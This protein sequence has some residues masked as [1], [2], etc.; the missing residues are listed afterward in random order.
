MLLCHN[1]M[2]E[3]CGCLVWCLLDEVIFV[4]F[5]KAVVIDDLL[6]R[7]LWL[8]AVVFVTVR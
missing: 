2:L 3:F 8:F 5:C 7:E 4:L 1:G 6:S